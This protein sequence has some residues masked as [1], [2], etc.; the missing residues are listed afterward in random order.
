MGHQWQGGRLYFIFRQKKDY[1]LWMIP[2]R[3]SMQKESMSSTVT[4]YFQQLFT[5]GNMW[6]T[7]EVESS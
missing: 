7:Y 6:D 5:C 4:I 3:T 2:I 1:K